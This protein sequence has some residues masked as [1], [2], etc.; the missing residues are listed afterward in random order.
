MKTLLVWFFAFLVLFLTQVRLLGDVTPV[1][2]IPEEIARITRPE[3]LPPELVAPRN[4]KKYEDYRP[5]LNKMKYGYGFQIHNL[6]G[7]RAVFVINGKLVEAIKDGQSRGA[8]V[9]TPNAY[10]PI[11]MNW[12]KRFGDPMVVGLFKLGDNNELKIGAMYVIHMADMFD[13]KLLPHTWI[14]DV[15]RMVPPSRM[16][17]VVSKPN[18]NDKKG[19]PVAHLKPDI[20]NDSAGAAI[21]MDR[22]VVNAAAGWAKVEPF[23]DK[24][25]KSLG[26]LVKSVKEG[27]PYDKAGLK[28]GMVILNAKRLD[29]G[30]LVLL[31][32]D[33]DSQEQR[34]LLVHDEVPPVAKTDSGSSAAGGP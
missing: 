23:Q 27:K 1:F 14:I 19:S 17:A 11:S 10:T 2:E 16:K 12:F 21:V 30:D 9:I 5:S 22:Y 6:S 18:F 7:S 31:V 20:S 29:S 25:G 24:D 28:V 13:D 8:L 26:L 34:Q 33:V 3:N 15:G 4:E 32:Q